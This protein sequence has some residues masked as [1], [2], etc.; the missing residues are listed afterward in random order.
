MI[1]CLTPALVCICPDAEHAVSDVPQILVLPSFC[2]VFSR[3]CYLHL[4]GHA[5]QLYLMQMS[6]SAV[7]STCS[8]LVHVTPLFGGDWPVM[9]SSMLQILCTLDSLPSLQ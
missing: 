8:Y 6:R 2:E 7:F 9:F 1:F 4:T 5:K 3:G